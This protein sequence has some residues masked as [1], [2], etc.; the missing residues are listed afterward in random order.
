V[1]VPTL[2]D[3]VVVLDA[4]TLDDAAAHLAGED[5]EHARRFGW[6]PRSSTPESVRN[7]VDRWQQEW[8]A[9][10]P[11]RALAARD[12]TS[13]ELVGGCELRLRGEEIAQLSYWVAPRHRRRGLATRIVRLVCE[14]AFRELGIERIEALVEPDNEASLGVVRAAGFVEEGV[15]RRRARFGDERR[16]MALYALLPSDF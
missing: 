16:D 11:T 8:R 5:E 14:F 4:F 7:A 15:L 1:L 13:S 3:G 2:T 9:D 10:G 6:F 12:A